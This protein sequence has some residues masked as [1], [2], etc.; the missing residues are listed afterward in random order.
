MVHNIL[1]W[2]AF[3]RLAFLEGNS[4]NTENLIWLSHFGPVF[5]N[6]LLGLRFSFWVTT[7]QM[8]RTTALDNMNR[9]GP[10]PH[11]PHGIEMWKLESE[12]IRIYFNTCAPSRRCFWEGSAGSQKYRNT[13]SAHSIIVSVILYLHYK[14]CHMSAISWNWRCLTCL[15][16]F[17]CNTF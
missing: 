11:L 3:V 14:H 17:L 12:Q 2:A 7:F 13:F 4:W 9:D 6:P 15:G 10:E 1:S 5:L 16:S 8:L